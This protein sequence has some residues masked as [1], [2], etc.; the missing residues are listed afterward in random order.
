MYVKSICQIDKAWLKG[1]LQTCVMNEETGEVVA[2]TAEDDDMALKIAGWLNNESRDNEA[3]VSSNAA[4]EIESGQL[5]ESAGVDF[6]AN[7]WTF[8]MQDGFTAGAG[9]YLII[10]PVD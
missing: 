3:S 5:A 6:E 9:K 1:R 7:E 10:R 2:I 4:K 8:K